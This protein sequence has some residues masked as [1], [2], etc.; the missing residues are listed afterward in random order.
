VFVTSAVPEGTWHFALRVADEVPNWSEISNAVTATVV[1]PDT[2]APSSVLDLVARDP[3]PAR[4]TLSWTAPG[5]DGTMGQAAAY[6]IRY[7]TVAITDET[8]NDATEALNELAPSEAG[9]TET[10]TLTTLN[11]E[12]TYYFA[13]KVTDDAGNVSTLSNVVS[14]ATTG[15]PIPPGAVTDLRAV[16]ATTR[17]ASFVWT[18]PG[19]D[20]AGEGQAAAYDLRRSLTPITDETWE[21]ATPVSGMPAPGLPG[22]Q[23]FFVV[24]GLESAMAYEFALRTRDEAGNESELSNSASGSTATSPLRLTFGSARGA[25]GSEWSPTDGGILYYAGVAFHE[26]VQEL[27]FRTGTASEMTAFFDGY[28]WDSSWSPDGTHIAFSGRDN[29]NIGNVWV[30]PD[31][32][33]ATPVPVAT[34]VGSETLSGPA[35]SPDGASIAYAMSPPPPASGARIWI[36]PASGGAPRPLES[37]DMGRNPSWSPD[38]TRIAFESNRTGNFEIWVIDVN[39]DNLTQLTFEPEADVQAAWSPDG[40]R[41]AFTSK[42]SGNYDIWFMSST[43]EILGPLDTDPGE[44]SSPSWSPDGQEMS[45]T[46]T[47]SG[48]KDIWIMPV[49]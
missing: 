35:W 3:G 10:F 28:A 43:G 38:G 42:R 19:S 45:F 8:W 15:D 7:S 27:S 12:T 21:D 33:Y 41:I 40:T 2:I 13:V 1:L 20:G 16:S 24:A 11:P 49:P 47:R 9:T 39:G 36:V 23:E 31:V 30:I 22:T 6:D 34:A 4:A 37:D 48:L 46:S 5:D 32:P 17:R 26:Q 14:L 44:D 18:A 25:Q 29:D